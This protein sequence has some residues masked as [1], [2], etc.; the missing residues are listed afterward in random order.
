MEN[1][2]SHRLSPRKNSKKMININNN[3][4]SF[5]LVAG[6][7]KN[8]TVASVG[9]EKII[10]IADSFFSKTITNKPNV[11]KGIGDDAAVLKSF[12][13]EFY[14]LVTIDTV[15]EGT[16]FTYDIS[17]EKIGWKA[18]AVN[19]SDIAA[20][21][22][23][24]ENAVI[25]VAIPKNLPIDF[26]EKLISGINSAAE[27]FNVAVVGGDTVGSDILSITITLLGKVEK[28]C[29][30]TRYG[31]KL[32]NVVAVTGTLGGSFKTEKHFNF[33]PRIEEARWLVKNAKPYAM[34]DLSDGLAMDSLRI[35]KASNVSMQFFSG[36]LPVTDGFSIENALND[37]EDFELLCVFPEKILTSGIQNKFE[38]R[39]N[40]KLSVIG[41]TA[42]PPA[43]IFL[44]GSE[45]KTKSFNHFV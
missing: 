11:I 37:G 14:Q 21:G 29:L 26:F 1:T 33:M 8:K 4:Y 12:S 3:L 20:M 25:S 27:K 9:E 41:K 15:V 35:A 31:A 7:G 5:D 17:P 23:I 22:G 43:K 13:D 36:K 24:P 30:C 40:L 19:I 10:S 44:D 38:E 42:P 18:M 34:M 39:F 28:Q 16:H 2:P 6:I 32:G 45:L